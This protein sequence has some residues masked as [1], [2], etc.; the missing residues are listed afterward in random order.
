MFQT[1]GWPE[2][3]YEQDSHAGYIVGTGIKQP[4]GQFVS[5]LHSKAKKKIRMLGG[6]G[7]DNKK[8][9]VVK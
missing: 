5:P 8:A 9:S 7:S 1:L 2:Y 4:E 3:K 6:G